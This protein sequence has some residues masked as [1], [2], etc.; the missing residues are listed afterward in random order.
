MESA[1]SFSLHSFQKSGTEINLC[2][3]IGNIEKKILNKN[4][5]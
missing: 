5:K 3:T 4:D 2:K 1:F